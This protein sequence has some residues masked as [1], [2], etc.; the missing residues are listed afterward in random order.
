MAKDSEGAETARRGNG[1]ANMRQRLDFLGGRMSVQ[2][3]PGAG[4]TI[5]FHIEVEA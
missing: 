2:C 5:G 1:L 4:T 3:T